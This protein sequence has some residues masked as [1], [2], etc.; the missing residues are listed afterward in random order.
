MTGEFNNDKIIQGKFE[1]SPFCCPSYGALLI[2][3]NISE[4][5]AD[6]LFANLFKSV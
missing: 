6:Q 5:F 2:L 3:R 4:I 1:G